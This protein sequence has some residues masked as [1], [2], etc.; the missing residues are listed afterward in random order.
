[1]I[2]EKKKST[3]KKVEEGREMNERRGTHFSCCCLFLFGGVQV[4]YVKREKI[5]EFIHKFDALKTTQ[6][7]N[8]VTNL[9]MTKKNH[10]E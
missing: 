4:T 10:D 8:P 5:I 3:R 2:H 1:L 9:N 7:P 6:H